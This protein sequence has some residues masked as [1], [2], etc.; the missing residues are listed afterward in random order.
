MTGTRSIR[1][2]A[3]CSA[4]T[5]A[6][7]LAGC[8]SSGGLS[9]AQLDSKVNAAC[10]TYKT[11]AMAIPPPTAKSPAAFAA[12][13]DKVKPL[14]STESNQ[15]TGLKAGGSVTTD[16]AS[17]VADAKHSIALFD[18]A[19]AKAHAKDPGYLQA[20]LAIA[21]YNRTTVDPLDTKLGFTACLPTG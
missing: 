17:Y 2:A 21:R 15:I 10:S 3:L 11:A 5:G 9:K 20:L 13:L 14:I 8:G 6:L 16:F 19:N 18:D 7:M 1:R 12:Y 4:A